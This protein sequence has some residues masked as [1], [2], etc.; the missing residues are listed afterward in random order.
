MAVQGGATAASAILRQMSGP[1]PRDLD[2]SG[3]PVSVGR[4]PDIPD[5]DFG[6]EP[7][8]APGVGREP[9]RIRVEIEDVHLSSD[10]VHH[11]NAW[12]PEVLDH[13]VHRI[14]PGVSGQHPPR[15]AVRRV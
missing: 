9:A 8:K 15:T 7:S 2:C 6:P 11:R 4:D 13:G 5:V 12:V 3:I 14:R 10:V 1:A